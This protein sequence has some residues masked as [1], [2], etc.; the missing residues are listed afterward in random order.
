MVYLMGGKNQSDG[1]DPSL[2]NESVREPNYLNEVWTWRGRLDDPWV[3]DFVGNEKTLC[4]TDADCYGDAECVSGSCSASSIMNYVQLDSPIEMLRLK[5][6]MASR[7]AG[8]SL[9]PKF[10]PSNYMNARDVFRLKAKGI[11]TIQQ[12]AD[13]SKEKVLHFRLPQELKPIKGPKGMSWHPS[14]DTAIEYCDVLPNFVEE[15]FDYKDGQHVLSRMSQICRAKDKSDCNTP[16][17]VV[18][19]TAQ[20]SPCLGGDYGTAMADRERYLSI[21]GDVHCCQW[22]GKTEAREPIIEHVCELKWLAQALVS[23]CSVHDDFWDVADSELTEDSKVSLK[24]FTGREDADGNLVKDNGYL[25]HDATLIDGTAEDELA[26]EFG[27]GFQ[28][29]N[30]GGAQYNRVVSDDAYVPEEEEDEWGEL[31]ETWDG[32]EMIGEMAV[33]ENGEA[34]YD[35][36]DGIPQVQVDTRKHDFQDAV[37]RLEEETH[38]RWGPGP[39]A[40]SQGVLFQGRAYIMGGMGKSSETNMTLDNSMWYRDSIPPTTSFTHTPPDDSSHIQFDFICDEDACV[41]EYRVNDYSENNVVCNWTRSAGTARLPWL[42]G[43]I[44]RMRVRAIDAAGNL[45][46]TFEAGRNELTWMYTPPLPI[47]LILGLLGAFLA[48]CTGVYLEYR[49]RRRKAAME[50]YAIK[51][52]RRKFKGGKKKKE[53]DVDWKKYGKGAKAS[54]KKGAKR[55]DEKGKGTKEKKN[56]KSHGKKGHKHGDGAGSKHKHAHKTHEHH[57]KKK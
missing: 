13:L 53:K 7:D 45:E 15:F 48:F 50:R 12:L 4:N 27:H 29:N 3:Q 20:V 2:L 54:A 11:H 44:H 46:N 47:A 25:T 8:F 34:A 23:K 24:A 51:R 56:K 16:P 36:V 57:A 49:R 19:G 31:V 43:G 55:K 32:C 9:P 37:W 6:P 41:F 14:P 10:R 1:R 21:Y 40:Y 22:V 39:R 18:G 38:C 33:D 35:E 28:Y 17:K 5:M 52:M 30:Q 26:P 42:G